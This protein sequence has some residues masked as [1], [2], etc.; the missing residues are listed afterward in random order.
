MAEDNRVDEMIET[1]ETEQRSDVITGSN[2]SEGFVESGEKHSQKKKTDRDNAKK[3]IRIGGYSVLACLFVLAICIAV[4]IL[5]DKLPDAATQ[6]DLSSNHIY[7]L[8]DESKQLVRDLDQDVTIYWLVQ[9]G[10]EDSPI[11]NLLSRYQSAGK[12]IT[13]ERVDPDVYPNFQEEYGVSGTVYNNSL[14]IESGGASRYIPYEDMYQT[15]YSMTGS[16]DTTF[17]GESEITAG[18]RYVTSTEHP[19][20]YNLTGHGEAVLDGTFR[21]AVEGQNYTVTDLSLL[22]SGA[23]PEDG[24]LLLINTPS[25]DISEDEK[26]M[27]LSYLQAGGKMLLVT[28]VTQ[29][30]TELQNVNSLMQYYG[31]TAQN[32][33]VI[34]GGAGYY[35]SNM[36]YM[37]L[38]ELNS[39]HAVTEPVST[40][41]YR[42]LLPI[43]QGLTVGDAPRDTVT[44]TSLMTTSDQA[45]SKISWKEMTS[46]EKEDGDTDGPFA[47]AVAVSETVENGETGII[48]ISSGAILDA[49]TNEQV[50]GANQDVFLN[51]LIWLS[52]SAGAEES[53]T[54]HAKAF[55]YGYLTMTSM[56][57]SILSVLMILIIPLGC[58][59]TGAVVKIRRK[60]R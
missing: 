56:T 16:S 44:V 30:G 34:E 59:I 32:G 38:P 24:A 6:M 58:L 17:A 5:M 57:G 12:K 52:D 10:K 53:T 20:I 27:I 29:D 50:S 9:S 7:S 39:S 42:V 45:Y 14:V 15:S 28:D 11:E 21:S 49:T 18:I 23:V 31:V 13:V 55:D 8:S 35:A 26:N 51:S 4:N 36:P 3:T 40:G 60:R 43:A 47:L 2:G 41:G 22:S 33:I 19:V 37:L 54:I 1:K 25:T 48:W 46:Y